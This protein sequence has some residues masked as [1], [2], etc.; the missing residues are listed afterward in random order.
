MHSYNVVD[1]YL[2]VAVITAPTYG[3]YLSDYAKIDVFISDDNFKEARLFANGNLLCV[4]NTMGLKPI[5]GTPPWLTM[6]FA[7]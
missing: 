2:P 1:R 5:C 6:A 4:W 3:S 7:F